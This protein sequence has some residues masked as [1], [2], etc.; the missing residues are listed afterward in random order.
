MNNKQKKLIILGDE[1]YNKQSKEVM[2]SYNKTTG[3]T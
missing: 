2:S 3:G 1:G